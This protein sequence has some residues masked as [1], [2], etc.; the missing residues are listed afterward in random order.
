[1]PG[2]ATRKQVE[3]ALAREA[4]KFDRTHRGVHRFGPIWRANNG[5]GCNWSCTPQVIGSN[6]PLDD[7]RDALE[8][9]Q[10]RYPVVDF[11]A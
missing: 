9:V 4:A 11:G 10:A 1:M 6:L 5:S 8:R 3:A 7:M 2:T